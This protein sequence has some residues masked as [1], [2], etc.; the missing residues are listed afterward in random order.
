MNNW[1]SDINIESYRGIRSLTL[2][3]LSMVNILTGDNNCGK[4][5]VLEVIRSFRQPDDFRQWISLTRSTYPFPLPVRRAALTQYELFSDLFDINAESKR[6]KYS[7][8]VND[9]FTDVEVCAVEA[10]AEFT[11][12]EFK[13]VFGYNLTGIF[14]S[15]ENLSQAII[16]PKLELE[17]RINGELVNEMDLYEERTRIGS[18]VEIRKEFRHN[19]I[20]ISPVDHAEGQLFLSEVLDSPELYAEM[21]EVL[22]AYDEN[23]MS[24]NYDRIDGSAIGRGTYKILSKSHEK[25]LPLN[26]YGDG[27]KK[28]ILLMSAVVKAKNGILLLDEFETAIHTSAMESTFKWILETCRRLNVQ[29]FLTSHSKEAIDK[30]LKC[31]PDLIEQISVYTLYKQSNQTTVRRLPGKKAIEVQDEMGLEL[32]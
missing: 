1:I 3:S 16:V 4:T 23:I 25:A 5:S 10:E 15:D 11:Q 31:A 30:V 8:I 17:I 32:R 27:M 6:I 18:E 13:E 19:I 9:C 20:Y 21:L 26:V 29:L 14:K 28:A 2:D 12:E 7:M 24:I 22:K